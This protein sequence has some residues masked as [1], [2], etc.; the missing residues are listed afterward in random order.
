MVFSFAFI[1]SEKKCNQNSKKQSN[2][3][4]SRFM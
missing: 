1:L 2:V 3:K 4:E